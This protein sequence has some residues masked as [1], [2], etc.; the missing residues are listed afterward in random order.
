M[1]TLNLKIIARIYNDY[2]H[3]FG[4]PR[5]S[6]LVNENIS[7]IV[8]EKDFKNEDALRDIENFSHLWLLWHFS[9]NDN[10]EWTP[11]V[12][13]PRLGGN[14]RIGVFATRSPFRPNPI[15]LSSVKL[16]KK[17]KTKNGT[18]LIVKG[19]DILSG[20]PIFDIKPYIKY[21]DCHPDAVCGFADD[22]QDY[23]LTVEISEELLNIIQKDKQQVIID[24]L[25]N[26]P[27]PSYQNDPNRIYGMCYGGYE[28]KFLVENSVL[29]VKNVANITKP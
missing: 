24:I 1:D 10:K 14:K 5:Q 9:D 19:A 20:T 17:E 29:T 23:S 4:I 22:F 13:P 27:R 25:K 15:G 26:D 12:R 6:G 8:F 21:T 7:T 18:V 2:S 11:C 28:I 16:I 3:K